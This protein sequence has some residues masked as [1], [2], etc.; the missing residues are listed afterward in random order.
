MYSSAIAS[1]L[2]LALAVLARVQVRRVPV[3]PVVLGRDRLEGAVVDGRVEQLLRELV[4]VGRL[5][6]AR[7][8][9]RD[10]LEH[11]L[12][13]V[14]VCERRPV[15]VRA[16]LRVGARLGPFPG[17]RCQISP[18]STP[19]LI[20]SSR[21]ASMSSTTRNRPWRGSVIVFDA[22]AELDRG[23]GAGRRELDAARSRAG[24]EVDVETPAEAQVEGLRAVDVGDRD[25]GDLELLGGGGGGERL[26]VVSLLSCVLLMV[27]LRGG[28]GWVVRSLLRCACP[29]RPWSPWSSTPGLRGRDPLR[30]RVAQRRERLG[31]W[32][33]TTT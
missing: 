17:S 22:L 30:R 11:P 23:G 15:E 19:R 27:T 12:V 8:P 4:D 21:A 9:L 13:A 20:R 10:F 3:P 2:A 1:A 28:C 7:Q 33:T 31:T 32:A 26:V 16:A 6:A 25:G 29:S 14:G 18:T 24:L 5:D